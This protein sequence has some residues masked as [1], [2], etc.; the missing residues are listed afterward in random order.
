MTGAEIGCAIRVE[1]RFVGGAH[2]FTSPD[3]K[4]LCAASR[5]LRAAYR[6]VGIQLDVL[7]NDGDGH[8][9]CFQPATSVEEF[10]ERLAKENAPLSG[11]A[12][13]WAVTTTSRT[14]MA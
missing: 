13:K 12:A 11:V 9:G 4:G 7:V 1:Y 10:E 2:F 5:D 14:A 3:V 6:A 8:S